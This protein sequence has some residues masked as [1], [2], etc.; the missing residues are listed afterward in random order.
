MVLG[1]DGECFWLCTNLVDKK[2][3]VIKPALNERAVMSR[4][5]AAFCKCFGAPLLATAFQIARPFDAA[6]KFGVIFLFRVTLRQERRL[7]RQCLAMVVVQPFVAV[8]RDAQGIQLEQGP[9]LVRRRC[10]LGFLGAQRQQVFEI[11]VGLV[12]PVAPGV[13]DEVLELDLREVRAGEPGELVGGDFVFRA[14]GVVDAAGVFRPPVGFLPLDPEA[15]GDAG[16]DAEDVVGGAAESGVGADVAAEVDDPGFVEFLAI[17]SRK[18][19]K[20]RLSM[21]LRLVM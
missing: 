12:D 1:G 2:S 10:G 14:A 17:S 20:V 7:G 4:A 18:P 21:K 3:R 11:V 13:G 9:F 16:L 15:D 6:I 19:S 8:G 5:N